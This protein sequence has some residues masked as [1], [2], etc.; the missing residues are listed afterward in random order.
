MLYDEQ[1]PSFRRS[2]PPVGPAW[3]QSVHGNGYH[4]IYEQGCSFDALCQEIYLPGKL[5]RCQRLCANS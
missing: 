4:W 3:G 1:R 5:D 2:P